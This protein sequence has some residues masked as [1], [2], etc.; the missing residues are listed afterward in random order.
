LV[1]APLLNG[2]EVAR[3]GFGPAG[4]TGIAVM[5]VGSLALRWWASVILGRFYTS[6]LRLSEGQQL[7]EKG[8]YRMVRHPGYAG[9]L[10]LLAGSRV[11]L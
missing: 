9:I 3:L 2:F 8:P 1:L 10:L 5:M 7:V 11:G 4:W 6:T